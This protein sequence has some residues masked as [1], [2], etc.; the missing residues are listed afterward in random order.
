MVPVDRNGA[1]CPKPACLAAAEKLSHDDHA[2]CELL[3]LLP[4]LGVRLG[5]PQQQFDPKQARTHL[6]AKRR[7]GFVMRAVNQKPLSAQPKR[8]KNHVAPHQ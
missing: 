5:E 1:N 8:G 7:V 4:R 2:Q 6:R 3:S